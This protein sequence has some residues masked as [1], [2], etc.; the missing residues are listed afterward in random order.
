MVPVLTKQLKSY[1]MLAEPP[2]LTFTQAC[3]FRSDLKT[4]IT[5]AKIVKCDLGQEVCQLTRSYNPKTRSYNQLS[6]TSQS[7]LYSNHFSGKSK[8][9]LYRK[10]VVHKIVPIVGKPFAKVINV[11]NQF[12]SGYDMVTQ[13]KCVNVK[14]IMK[15]QRK[16]K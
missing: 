12:R 4:V 11:W 9:N 8:V 14:F 10:K 6:I 1:I 5:Q 2:S 13:L 3:K 7:Q 15:L 16:L